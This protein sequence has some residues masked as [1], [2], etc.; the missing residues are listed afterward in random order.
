M[1]K[2]EIPHPYP[3]PITITTTDE[4][5]EWLSCCCASFCVKSNIPHVSNRPSLMIP[6]TP[7]H[8]RHTFASH[9]RYLHSL[10]EVGG[11]E[12]LL[13]LLHRNVIYDIEWPMIHCDT[14]HTP[15]HSRRVPMFVQTHGEFIHP[16]HSLTLDSDFGMISVGR[17]QSCDVFLGDISDPHQT[18]TDMGIQPY[19]LISRVHTLIVRVGE[20]IFV[21][22]I[23][24]NTGFKVRS[25]LH[26][27]W[28]DTEH[29]R[30]R[31]LRVAGFTCFHFHTSECID[32]EFVDDLTLSIHKE[33]PHTEKTVGEHV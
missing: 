8:E 24:S 9:A 7:W 32:I 22:D 6:L 25:S 21:M 12:S 28:F 17:S 2:N 1:Q 33:S 18:K 11:S 15:R 27:K 20:N 29:D 13:K 5:N 10:T 3:G 23:S 31:A 26:K 14:I 16:N 4:S 30:E 19:H